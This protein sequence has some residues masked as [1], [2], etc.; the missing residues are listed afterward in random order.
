MTSCS[1]IQNEEDRLQKLQLAVNQE[2]SKLGGGNNPTLSIIL[3][4]VCV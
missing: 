2:R 4:C 1:Q 3:C